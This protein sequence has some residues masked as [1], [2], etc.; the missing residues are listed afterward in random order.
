M[1]LTIATKSLHY[2]TMITAKSA[3]GTVKLAAYL[4]G[5]WDRLPESG[6][7]AMVDILKNGGPVANVAFTK[8]QFETFKNIAKDHGI[9]YAVEYREDIEGYL[10]T[11]RAD[12]LARFDTVEKFRSQEAPKAENTKTETPVKDTD[13]IKDDILRDTGTVDF[14]AYK[15]G[16]DIP[17]EKHHVIM[18]SDSPAVEKAIRDVKREDL[19]EARVLGTMREEKIQILAEAKK[20]R[21]IP[22][23]E[24][25]ASKGRGR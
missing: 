12:D 14:T 19:K 5:L 6:R 23:K 18:T 10:V 21:N 7:V 9:V 22:V 11:M 17:L 3:K 1:L 15:E 16:G 20:K 25:T 24:K 2:T 4:K 13:S 8:E